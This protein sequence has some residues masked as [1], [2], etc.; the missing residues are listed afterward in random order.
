VGPFGSDELRS[1][2]L[3]VATNLER[4]M[5]R[6]HSYETSAKF[7]SHKGIFKC[8][9]KAG[10]RLKGRTK[11][12]MN[13]WFTLL[14]SQFVIETIWAEEEWFFSGPVWKTTKPEGVVGRD[15]EVSSNTICVTRSTPFAP[16]RPKEK[17]L[18]TA[19]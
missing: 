5:G 9:R 12:P 1:T 18:K 6:W 15:H 7:Y 11:S 14:F 8:R 3:N 16:M 2:G 19:V 4:T 13:D 10:L 17:C